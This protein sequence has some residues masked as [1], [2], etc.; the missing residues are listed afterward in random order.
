MNDTPTAQRPV[1]ITVI[2]ILGFIGAALSI[3]VIFSSAASNIGGW[4]PPVLGISALVGVICMIGLWKMKKWAVFLY[5]AMVVVIQ[6]VLFSMHLW[7]PFSLLFPA[8]IIAIG[9]AYLSRMS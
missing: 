9:F 2:C 7:A 8:I 1:A 5:T 6:I 4:Y 3:P